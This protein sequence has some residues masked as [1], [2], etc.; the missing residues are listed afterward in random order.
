M[1]HAILAVLGLAVLTLAVNAQTKI[2]NTILSAQKIANSAGQAG[3]TFNKLKGLLGGNKKDKKAKDTVAAPKLSDV[4]P[5]AVKTIISISGIEYKNLQTLNENIRNCK[6][7]QSSKMAFDIAGSQIEV[8]H[9]GTT[10]DLMK[11][12]CETSK[13]IF[14]DKNIA[15]LGEGKV[16][17]KL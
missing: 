5:S 8:T 6:G 1:K 3:A 13:D 2:D 10:E 14:T 7:V 9:S 16:A 15:S 11:L 4:V 17:L 12:V